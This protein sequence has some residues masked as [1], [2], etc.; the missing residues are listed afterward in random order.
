MIVRL[1]PLGK[2]NKQTKPIKIPTSISHIIHE[3]NKETKFKKK[4]KIKKIIYIYIANPNR[5]LWILQQKIG[6]HQSST[7]TQ[8]Q[9][10]QIVLQSTGKSERSNKI[11]SAKRSITLIEISPKLKFG[12]ESSS[13]LHIDTGS[14]TINIIN[15]SL[16]LFI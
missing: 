14:T 9:E 12:Y 3:K 8:D 4:K 7:Q 2:T 1:K 11:Q 13:N 16:Y 6:I 5:I 15:V 10:E